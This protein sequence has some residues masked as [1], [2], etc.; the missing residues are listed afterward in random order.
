MRTVLLGQLGIIQRLDRGSYDVYGFLK[1]LR[2]LGYKGPVGLQC[3]NVS[4]D[5][6]ENLAG[7]ISAW[8]K[9]VAKMATE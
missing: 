4:G 8:K 2:K 3:Y 6:K 9:F 5:A 1:T 7:S